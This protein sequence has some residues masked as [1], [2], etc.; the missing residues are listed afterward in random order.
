MG[1]TERFSAYEDRA[2]ALMQRI[3][4]VGKIG[5]FY[6]DKSFRSALYGTG[7]FNEYEAKDSRSL[8]GVYDEACEI[9]WLIEDMKYAAKTEG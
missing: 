5:V 6:I 1:A 3:H 2:N 8:I 4:R 7:I 9:D